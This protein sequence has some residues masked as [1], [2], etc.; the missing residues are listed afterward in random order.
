MKIS[1]HLNFS[2]DSGKISIW[3]SFFLK[4]PIFV[5]ILEKNVEIS[6][7]KK[8]RKIN[9]AVFSGILEICHNF[10]KIVILVKI[11]NKSRNQTNEKKISIEV[12]FF[13]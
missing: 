4:I 2:Q 6:K 12:K 5:K 3:A 13:F 11:V 8:K 10:R 7:K 9:L 1:K